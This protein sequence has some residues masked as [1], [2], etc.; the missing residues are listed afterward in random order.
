MCVLENRLE[1]A[2]EVLERFTDGFSWQRPLFTL[3]NICYRTCL[4]IDRI[5]F[6]AL[7]ALGPL[8]SS[9]RRGRQIG[10]RQDGKLSLN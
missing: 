6:L 5:Y 9:R 1:M 2:R 7:L 3:Q 10:T 4:I 8:T